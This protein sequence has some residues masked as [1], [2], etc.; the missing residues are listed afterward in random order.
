MTLEN[1][2]PPLED[3]KRIPAG[4]FTDSLFVWCDDLQGYFVLERPCTW[5][6]TVCPAPTLEEILAELPTV[7][8]EPDKYVFLAMFD[9]RNKDDM[10][11]FGYTNK[12]LAKNELRERDKTPATAALRLWERVK[13][14]QG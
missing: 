9:T 3:C 11:Q 1:L 6:V 14:V 12:A 2:V 5:A 4:K 13:G 10:F 7:I 8:E